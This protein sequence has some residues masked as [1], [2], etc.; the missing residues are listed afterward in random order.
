MSSVTHVLQAVT[1]GWGVFAMCPGVSWAGPAGVQP[2]LAQ[3]RLKPGKQQ[4]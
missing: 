4:L 1:S 3:V 2:A